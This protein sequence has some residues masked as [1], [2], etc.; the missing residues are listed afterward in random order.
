[1]IA[2]AKISTIACAFGITE[3]T[4][5]DTITSAKSQPQITK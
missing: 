3:A 1:M 4:V 2:T 5:M